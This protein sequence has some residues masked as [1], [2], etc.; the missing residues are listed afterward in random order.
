MYGVEVSTALDFRISAISKQRKCKIC[1]F[2]T[3]TYLFSFCDHVKNF[4][5]NR[6]DVTSFRL[7]VCLL[8]LH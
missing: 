7:I 5:A 1:L 2:I 6:I 3:Y 8:H 4:L